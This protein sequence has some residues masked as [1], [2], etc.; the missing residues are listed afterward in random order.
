M[1]GFSMFHL[2]G[3]IF[4]N[5]QNVMLC[6]MYCYSRGVPE[7][8]GNIE[9]GGYGSH[10]TP[11]VPL[12]SARNVTIRDSYFNGGDDNICIKNDTSNVLVEN[13]TV[14]DGHGITLG[15]T[16]DGNGL[17]GYNENITFKGITLHG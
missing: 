8:G 4:R 15:S 3:P 10:G 11:T 2:Q 7:E 12:L 6:S 5:S 1:E 13:C 16:P 17:H 14:G 9:V